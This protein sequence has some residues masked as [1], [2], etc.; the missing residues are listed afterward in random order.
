MSTRCK[1][2][3]TIEDLQTLDI[4]QLVQEQLSLETNLVS[5]ELRDQRLSKCEACSKRSNHTCTLCGCFVKFRTSLA[6]KSCPVK[7]W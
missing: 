5:E 2:C 1:S 3:K 7:K 4:D 6:N